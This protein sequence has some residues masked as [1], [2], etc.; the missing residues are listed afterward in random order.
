MS[1]IFID[2][3]SVM[4]CGFMGDED[5]VHYLSQY[6]G[7]IDEK[8]RYWFSANWQGYLYLLS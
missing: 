6:K 2:V 1:E 4:S 5:L 8:V 3:A 7:S